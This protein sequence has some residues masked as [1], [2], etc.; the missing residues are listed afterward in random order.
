MDPDAMIWKSTA[1]RWSIREV[2]AHV[3]DVERRNIFKRVNDI[4]T[5]NDPEILRAPPE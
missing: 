4:A 1:D 3:V 5:I 2:L